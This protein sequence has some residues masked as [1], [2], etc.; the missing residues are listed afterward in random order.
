MRCRHLFLINR[1]FGLLWFGQLVSQLGD[2]AYNIVLMWW[3]IEKTASPLFVSSFLVISVIPELIFS[4]VAGG[5]ID[6]W[7]KKRILIVADFARGMSR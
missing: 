2:K 7:N 6:R 4:L 5:C 3:L 1:N